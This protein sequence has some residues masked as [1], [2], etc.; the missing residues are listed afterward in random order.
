MLKILLRGKT[1]VNQKKSLNGIATTNCLHYVGVE[2]KAVLYKKLLQPVD[3]YTVY[4]PT[5]R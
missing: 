3:H 1:K 4:P 5:S 2:K